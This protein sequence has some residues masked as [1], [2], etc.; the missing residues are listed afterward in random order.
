L[1]IRPSLLDW[2]NQIADLIPDK[3]KL[4]IWIET[5]IPSL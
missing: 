1:M 4:N 2:C 5:F 3:K